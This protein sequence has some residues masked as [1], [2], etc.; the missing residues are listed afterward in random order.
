MNGV[1]LAKIC[2]ELAYS[3]NDTLSDEIFNSTIDEIRNIGKKYGYATLFGELSKIWPISKAVSFFSKAD[4]DLGMAHNIKTIATHYRR[5][6][7]GGV[8]RVQAQL[9]NLW[10]EMGYNVVLFTEEPENE[11]DYQYPHSVKRIIIPTG[12]KITERLET[13]QRTCI[14]EKVDLYVS[15]NWVSPSIIW[16]CM[17]LKMIPIPFIQYIHG[18]FAWNIWTSRE[19]LYQPEVFKQSNLVLSLS[20]TNARFYQLC[21]CRSYLVQNPIP[22]DLIN[23]D[24]VSKLDSKHILMVGRLS[25]EKHPMDA[26]KIFKLVHDKIPEAVLDIVGGDD[27]DFASQICNYVERNKLQRSVLYYGKKIQSEVAEFYQKSACVIF[28]S[29]MEGYPMVIL[30]TKAY[31][32]PLV[33]YELPYLSLVRDGKGVITAKQG[34]IAS[35]AENI[36]KLLQN[37]DYRLNLGKEAKESFNTVINYDIKSAWNNIITLCTLGEHAIKDVAYYNPAEVTYADRFIEPMLFDGIKKGYEEILTSN[38]Y[39]QAGRKILKFPRKL[40]K[41][42]SALKGIIKHG[43]K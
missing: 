19:N 14:E 12:D 21:G 39:Y 1:N 23:S 35:M 32:L 17:T 27:G 15:H 20:E 6:Y 34:D 4:F 8:E 43:K 5:C 16:E 28:T 2:S 7:S 40:K 9:M 42:L 41:L 3:V 22:E 33:M 26:L 18:N 31:G 11:L 37:D 24:K 29:E 38:L 10:V 36:V 25:A 13:L 30:E